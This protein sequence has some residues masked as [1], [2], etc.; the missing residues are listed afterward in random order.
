[1]IELQEVESSM[2]AEVGYDAESSRLVVR[3][4][5]GP[6]Y[7]YLDVPLSVW[8]DLLGADSVGSFFS[9]FIRN[10]YTYSKLGE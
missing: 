2:L 1:M 8:E 9:N 7:E 10:E 5:R 6:L 3:F 4:T